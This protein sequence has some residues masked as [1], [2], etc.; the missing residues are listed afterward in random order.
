MPGILD[1][2]T[3]YFDESD[4]H[5]ITGTPIHVSDKAK[6]GKFPKRKNLK[7]LFKDEFH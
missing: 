4:Y 6:N 7:E 2:P 3:G 1:E 5:K